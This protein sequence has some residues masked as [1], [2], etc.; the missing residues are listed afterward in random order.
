MPFA[1][2][3]SAF[4]FYAMSMSGSPRR[5][6]PRPLP[7]CIL[8][9]KHGRACQG[10]RKPPEGPGLDKA[11]ASGRLRAVMG[12]RRKTYRHYF[13]DESFSKFSDISATSFSISVDRQTVVRGPSL[14]GFGYLPSLQPCHQELL[15]M[16]KI[17]S[18]WGRRKNVTD[19]F[20]SGIILSFAGLK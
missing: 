19:D 9:R 7:A 8:R 10:R 4:C 16:G 20:S 3:L 11:S 15:L 17:S 13:L 5:S 1:F 12:G 2:C 6:R 14:S 18:T